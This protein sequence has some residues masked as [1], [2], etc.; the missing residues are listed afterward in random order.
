MLSSHLSV[1]LTAQLVF[2]I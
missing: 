2:C 1:E